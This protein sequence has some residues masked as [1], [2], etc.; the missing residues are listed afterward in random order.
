MFFVVLQGIVPV[1]FHNNKLRLK[2]K[3]N[4]A[5]VGRRGFTETAVVLLLYLA[6]VETMPYSEPRIMPPRGSH[7][8]LIHHPGLRGFATPP[9]G[10]PIPPRAQI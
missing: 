3:P 7:L 9:P 8:F 2:V 6:H 1:L 5:T 10:Y 4:S